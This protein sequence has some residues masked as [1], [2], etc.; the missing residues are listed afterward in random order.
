MQRYLLRDHVFLAIR[1]PIVFKVTDHHE[2]T[3]EIDK[4]FTRDFLSDSRVSHIVY[5]PSRAIVSPC[6]HR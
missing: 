4:L 2:K 1:C 3:N 5:V 6:S